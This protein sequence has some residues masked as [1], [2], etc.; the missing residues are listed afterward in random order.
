MTPPVPDRDFQPVT[1]KE[2]ERALEEWRKSPEA[3]RDA[4]KKARLRKDIEIEMKAKEE[5][6]WIKR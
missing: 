1:S 3:M 5:L 2:I 6:G 4:L